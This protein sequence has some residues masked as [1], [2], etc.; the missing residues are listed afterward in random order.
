MRCK[1]LLAAIVSVAF[2]IAAFSGA[3]IGM[4]IVTVVVEAG[5]PF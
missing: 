5:N 3:S 2:V 1:T 4:E